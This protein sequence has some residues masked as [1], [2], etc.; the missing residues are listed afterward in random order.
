MIKKPKDYSKPRPIR[1]VLAAAF[2]VLCGHA[3]RTA[4]INRDGAEA[5]HQ[6]EFI[7]TAATAIIGSVV[8]GWMAINN[9]RPALLTIPLFMI[10]AG[11]SAFVWH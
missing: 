4:M 3:F 8:V 6:T 1:G 9:K 10:A 2:G 11:V 5:V 7:L